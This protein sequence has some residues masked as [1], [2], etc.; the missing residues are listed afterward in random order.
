[1]KNSDPDKI[2][3]NI[4]VN[5]ILL[6]LTKTPMKMDEY[7]SIERYFNAL[8][9]AC[10]IDVVGASHYY[11]KDVF[12]FYLIIED[13]VKNW[14]KK[15]ILKKTMADL[16]IKYRVIEYLIVKEYQDIQS[17]ILIAND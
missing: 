12:D 8:R 4:S 3:K 15:V 17:N 13:S 2:E 5:D 11:N 14:N 10:L 1:M 6:K 16:I 9:D 7:L